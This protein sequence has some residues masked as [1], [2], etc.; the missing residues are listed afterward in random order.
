MRFDPGYLK[1]ETYVS[2]SSINSSVSEN[3]SF[4]VI[5]DKIAENSNLSDFRYSTKYVLI[6]V[7]IYSLIHTQFTIRNVA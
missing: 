5:S 4:P 7:C 2:I 3:D 1:L 6:F